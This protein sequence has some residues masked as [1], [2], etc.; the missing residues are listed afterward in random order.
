[1]TSHR[2][3]FASR[4]C[5]RGPHGDPGAAF[6]DLP[7]G[8]GEAVVASVVSRLGTCGLD[9]DAIARFIEA[10]EANQDPN[11]RCAPGLPDAAP[12]EEAG[13]RPVRSASSVGEAA[14]PTTRRRITPTEEVTMCVAHPPIAPFGYRMTE[15]GLQIHALEQHVLRLIHALRSCTFS[16]AEI[17]DF[18]AAIPEAPELSEEQVGQIAATP[19][20]W[21]AA[22]MAIVAED[23]PTGLP[24]GYRLEAGQVV[25][26]E[27]HRRALAR[28][29]ARR[30]ARLGGHALTITDVMVELNLLKRVGD[31]TRWTAESLTALFHQE[32]AGAHA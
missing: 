13:V 3:P 8:H 17:T 14:A 26:Q 10:F 30:G 21:C 16:R 15:R 7:A 23:R 2:P 6:A 29:Q 32:G 27:D 18:L 9:R 19:P 12:A 4:P 1:M 22:M 5:D 24:S 11:V 20:P 28:V 31:E 25:L